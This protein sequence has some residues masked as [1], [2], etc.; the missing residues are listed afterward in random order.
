[1]RIL[2]T[3]D[4]DYVFHNDTIIFNGSYSVGDSE[5]VEVI[6]NAL[7]DDLVEGTELFFADI[8]RINLHVFIFI[9]DSNCKFLIYTNQTSL[10]YLHVNSLS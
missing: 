5:C 1:M 10:I 3:A 2:Y 4:L 6:I 8:N 9:I 7:K